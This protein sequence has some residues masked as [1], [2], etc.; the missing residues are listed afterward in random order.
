MLIAFHVLAW[1]G[2]ACAIVGMV[3]SLK[4]V[5]RRLYWTGQWVMVSGQIMGV[6]ALMFLG[7]YFAC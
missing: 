7:L 4:C 3:I 2:L 1:V 6:L 5:S